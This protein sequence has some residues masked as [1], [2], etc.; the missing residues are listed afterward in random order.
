MRRLEPSATAGV[1]AYP[2]HQFS[3]DPATGTL[4][5]LGPPAPDNGARGRRPDFRGRRSTRAA[6][7]DARPAGCLRGL[8]SRAALEEFTELRR[9]TVR[10]GFGTT[11]SEG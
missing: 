7:D 9:M 6:V 3:I 1:T 8:A 2:V 5:S 4:T 11:R 10:E